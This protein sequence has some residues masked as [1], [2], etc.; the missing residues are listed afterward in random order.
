MPQISSNFIL[1]SKL[2]NFER[3]AFQTLKAMYLVDSSW[4]DEGHI[5]YCKQDGKHYIFHSISSTGET[6]TGADRWSEL[7]P[8]TL[9]TIT[10][11]N[12][13]QGLTDSLAGQLNL[14]SIV[15][16]ENGD[17]YY[18]NAYDKTKGAA[19]QT[20]ERLQDTGW[21]RPLLQDL[22]GYVTT[23]SLNSRLAEYTK[24]EDLEEVIEELLPTIEGGVSQE[25]LE[26]TLADYAT[27]Q[28]LTAVSNQTTTNTNAIAEVSDRVEEL[29]GSAVTVESIATMLTPYATVRM[30]QDADAGIISRIQNLEEITGIADTS[31]DEY[32]E[33]VAATYA[34]KDELSN[35]GE[36]ISEVSNTLDEYKEEVAATYATPDMISGLLNT[37]APSVENENKWVSSDLAGDLAGKTGREIASEAYSYSAVLDRILFNDFTPTVSEPSVTMKLKESWLTNAGVD[38]YNEDERVIMVNAGIIGPDGSD[39]IA[40]RIID[41]EISYPKGLSFEKGY[42]NGLIPSTDEQ[43]TSVGFCRIK[44]ENGEWVYY[45]GPY[46]V[47][48]I[49]EPGS[50][51]YYLAAYFNA[52]YPARNNTGNT[53]SE[54]AEST[55]VESLDYVTINA[56][57]PIYYNTP[58]GMVEKPLKI[59]EDVMFDT[60]ELLPSCILEQSF[61]VP[62][63]LKALYIWNDLL[64][65]YGQVP[66]MKE[67]NAEGLE[68]ENLVPAYF[69]ESV[70]ENGYYIYKYNSDLYGHRGA[71][72]IKVEF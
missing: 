62:R 31:L 26:S 39:I 64:G 28:E 72:K 3:D 54:W 55:A 59:W 41:A 2:S 36:Q 33:E 60:A 16:V 29:E 1:R 63:K 27:K 57:K 56:S 15:Y 5:S 48:S 23:T 44:N 4:M 58:E 49:L 12:N 20:L 35:I 22:S 53:V 8:G 24:T 10:V 38:W 30:V 14:G 34:T 21:F 50:Y 71:I 40:D 19:V 32:K 45:G 11:V 17:K 66:M 9:S 13:L 42:T 69:N 52:G 61:M 51:R 25:D 37:Y 43:Q 70:D 68:T 18:Y 47:P 65:G 7:I 67:L 46:H 6:L